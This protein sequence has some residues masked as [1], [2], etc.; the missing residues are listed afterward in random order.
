MDAISPLKFDT[1]KSMEDQMIS[2]TNNLTDSCIIEGSNDRDM[3]DEEESATN[4][5]TL[6][7]Y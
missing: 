6:T 5:N 1:K 2:L 3:S 4:T 7:N